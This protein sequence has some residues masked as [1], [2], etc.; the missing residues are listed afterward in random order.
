MDNKQES[1]EMPKEFNIDESQ[2]FV[3]PKL[4]KQN[5]AQNTNISTPFTSEAATNSQN[6][7]IFVI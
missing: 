4:P 3:T 6:K 5:Q 2:Q 1:V 7:P